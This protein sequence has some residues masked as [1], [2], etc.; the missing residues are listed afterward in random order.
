MY[1]TYMCIISAVAYVCSAHR[2]WPLTSKLDRYL[3]FFILPCFLCS[4]VQIV[5]LIHH[6]D[7]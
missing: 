3:F 7:W 1:E 6:C 5:L 2:A 4:R